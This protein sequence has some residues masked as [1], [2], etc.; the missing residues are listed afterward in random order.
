M[1]AQ[2]MGDFVAHHHGHFVICELQFVEYAGVERNLAAGHAIGIDLVG[3]DQVD[4]P[5]PLLRPRVPGAGKGRN[6]VHDA[7]QA[8]YLR[9]VCRPQRVLFSSLRQG[10]LVLQGGAAFHLVGGD[11]LGKHRGLTHLHAFARL[12]LHRLRRRQ[13]G[14]QT[15]T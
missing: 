5:F 13:G 10:L 4:F 3:A 7:A 8:L 6:F 2:S 14:Q 11:H 9:M 15:Q 12:C 1:F